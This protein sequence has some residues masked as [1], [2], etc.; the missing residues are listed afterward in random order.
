MP[1]PVAHALAGGLVAALP[2]AGLLRSPRALAAVLVAA[3]APDLDFLAALAGKAMHQ[4]FT[5]SAA[6]ALATALLLAP[7][8]RSVLS[9]GPAFALLALAA[10]SHLGLDLVSFDQYPP[11][12]IPLLWPLSEARWHSPWTVF[13]GVAKATL[14]EIPSLRNLRELAVELA[15]LLPPA[16][17]ALRLRRAREAAG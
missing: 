15:L 6:F 7:L 3:N 10:L 16:L 4:H 11:V 8:L 5:H 14:A 9:A 13:P 1:S 12:G 17:L 2:R